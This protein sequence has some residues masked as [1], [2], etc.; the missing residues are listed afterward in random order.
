MAT[1][2]I[3]IVI[4]ENGARVVKRRLEEIGEVAQN[5]V[6]GLRLLQNSLFVLGGA[7]LLSA[8]GS[9]VDTVNNFRNRLS[10]L[11]DSS[12][13]AAQIQQTL[14][15]IAKRTRTEFESTS[16]VYTRTALAVRTLGISQ[17]ETLQFTESLNKATI[18][19]GANVREANAALIQMSQAL[20]SN[21]FSGDEFRSVSEQLPFIIDVIG[22]YG[23]ATKKTRGEVRQLGIEGKLTAAVILKAFREAREDIDSKFAKTIPTLSQSFTV[24]RV[25][26]M[27]V[28]GTMDQALGISHSLAAIVIMVAENLQVLTAGVIAA[29]AAFAA[30]KLTGWVASAVVAIQRSR[31]LAA[32]VASGNAVL[33]TS[34]EIEKAK[35]A[36]AL[37]SA[38]AE[39]TAA[40]AKVRSLQADVASLAT[41]RSLLVSQQA[42]IVIDNQRRIARDALTGR[43]IAYN[44]AVAQNIR[45]NIAL[46]RTEQMMVATKAEL[47]AAITAQTAAT[48]ALSAAQTRSVAAG[49]A[50][51]TWTARLATTFPT[52]AAGARMVAG[53]FSGMTAAI[54]ANPIGAIL[55]VIAAIVVA[56]VIFSDKIGIAKDGM[57]TLRD[58]GIAVFQLIRDGVVAVAGVITDFLGPAITWISDKWNWLWT[59]IQEVLAG[60]LNGIKTFVNVVIGLF[61][62]LI[63]GIIRSWDLLPAAALDVLKIVYNTYLQHIQDTV[64]LFIDMP[65]YVKAAW[66]GIA[67]LGREALDYIVDAFR[68]LP[69]AI[70]DLAQRAATFLKNEF[71]KAINYVIGLLNKL[72]GVAID[73]WGEVSDAVKDSF[74][75]P[76]AADFSNL[77][78]NG[79]LDL[80]GLKAQTSG[81]AQEVG[82]IFSEEFGKSLN[83]DYIGNAWAEVLRRAEIN[84]QERL[85]QAGL[86]RPGTPSTTASGDKGKGK[87]FEEIV[88]ELTRENELLKVNS[89]ERE[90][91]Q[92]IIKIEKKLKRSLTETERA[93]IMSLLD[94]NQ[95]LKRAAEIY[96]EIN[97]P[98]EKY[99]TT[100][101]AL[102]NLMARG[103]IT[104]D[105]FI[106]KTRDARITFLNSQT[107]MASGMER[108]FLKVLQKGADAATQ[109]ENIVTT[110]F[111]GMSK[112]I[113]DLVVDGTA[114][115]GSLI[116]SINKM[117]IQLVVSQA[118][119]QLFGG[120]TGGSLTGGGNMFSGLLTG[121]KGLFGFQDG[122]QFTVGGGMGFAPIPNGGNDNR[123]VAFRAQDGETVSV[124]PKGQQPGGSQQN[125]TVNF[126]ISTPNVESFR[127]SESQ[128]AAKAAR[129]I[130]QGRRNM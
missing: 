37:A 68:K 25:S 17:R 23:F 42:S 86:D 30:F 118:F 109:M 62:G 79:H 56:L 122:G 93:L 9:M 115:F 52:L 110:A 29:T 20:A 66:E 53:A 114:D 76:T 69:G 84:A 39:N 101:E 81:A 112:A 105:Q 51:S 83:T 73:A 49:V 46:Q 64:N 33:L 15:D 8:L 48:T 74:T 77:V 67:N 117:I 14:F 19:S 27:E 75:L 26:L 87:S 107:D 35:A 99:K 21:R 89:A 113:A 94:E 100:L 45:T 128:L 59:K 50:A 57:I 38:A 106:M 58:V 78:N 70:A 65:K 103:A 3:D 18:L 10:L 11:T 85:K 119:Q 96:E 34:T 120:F 98:A 60:I 80:S 92:K 102:N 82:Q 36:T 108:G 31:E 54:A 7:G 91:L 41:Q 12:A 95:V 104:T 5:S 129:L 16:Q 24:F 4:Q 121:L 127:Q 28:I 125:V 40:A 43:F 1:E 2:R 97:G 116:K 90:K 44:A 124:T 13:E 111:D 55:A 71:V 6:R 126:N 22:D 63:N 61:V 88:K 72:P 123:L 130:S 32:A 47:T